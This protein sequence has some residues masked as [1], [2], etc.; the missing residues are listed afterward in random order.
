MA[1]GFH[2]DT[3]R[4]DLLSLGSKPHLARLNETVTEHTEIR[5]IQCLVINEAETN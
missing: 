4:V 2:M 1:H 3:I 5:S